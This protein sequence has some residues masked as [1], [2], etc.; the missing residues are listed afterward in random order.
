MHIYIYIY[1]YS[2]GAVIFVEEKF[3]NFHFWKRPPM[4]SSLT[5]KYKQTAWGREE[6]S[7]TKG[8]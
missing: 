1:I 3:L 4:Q 8:A 2:S 7:K 5:G 6:Q